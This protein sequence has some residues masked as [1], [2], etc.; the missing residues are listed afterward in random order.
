MRFATRALPN[1]KAP[2]K[3]RGA[4]LKS[5]CDLR[6]LGVDHLRAAVADRDLARLHRLR[7]LT[8]EID[9]QESV[10]E[11]RALDLDMLGELEHALERARRD[12]LVE[13]LALLLLGLGLLLA[14]DRQ[15][16]LL[17]RDRELFLREARAR[18]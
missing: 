17:R 18:E 12:A 1:I 3:I 2:R 16:V 6:R 9:V 4:P 8:H 7:D 13:H 11:R 10:L 15:R 5:R 14:L